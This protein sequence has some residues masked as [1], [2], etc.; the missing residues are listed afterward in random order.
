MHESDIIVH[1]LDDYSA[2]IK[3]PETSRNA[4]AAWF[5]EGA[6][7]SYE[8]ADVTFTPWSDWLRMRKDASQ[9]GSRSSIMKQL[10]YEADEPSRK[11]MKTWD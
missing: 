5:Q 11:R 10:T 4:I 8:L 3:M 9:Q 2:C 1:W 6:S 7:V